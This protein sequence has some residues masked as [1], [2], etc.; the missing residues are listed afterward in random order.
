MMHASWYKYYFIYQHIDFRLSPRVIEIYTRYPKE[1]GKYTAKI[2]FD[3]L[4]KRSGSDLGVGLG[5]RCNHLL[6]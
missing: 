6:I 1:C 5:L 3:S 4:T 2:E